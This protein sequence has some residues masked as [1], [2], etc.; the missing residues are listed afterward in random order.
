MFI[1]YDHAEVP[2][3]LL[4][5]TPSVKHWRYAELSSLSNWFCVSIGYV[6][7]GKPSCSTL[8]IAGLREFEELLGD[9]NDDLW[10]EDV[11]LVTSSDVNG[12]RGW[13]ME[14]LSMLSEAVS[15][16]N[17]CFSYIYNLENGRIYTE[18][19]FLSPHRFVRIIF[20]AAADVTIIDG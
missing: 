17:G 9:R 6:R 19:E 1:T 18:G 4:A 15:E 20:D 2:L 11:L 12:S 8:L 5:G 7:S 13:Q 3:G 16:S 10:I 14:R